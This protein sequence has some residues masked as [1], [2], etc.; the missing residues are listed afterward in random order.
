MLRGARWDFGHSKNART[1]MSLKE[2]PRGSFWCGEHLEAEGT[3]WGGTWGV[4]GAWGAEGTWGA[5]GAW[6]QP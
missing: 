6:K 3:W 4:E 1:M 5:E 2:I